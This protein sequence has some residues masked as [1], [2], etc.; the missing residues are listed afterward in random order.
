MDNYDVFSCLFCECTDIS[1]IVVDVVRER[2]FSL[3]TIDNALDS[4]INWRSEVIPAH[5]LCVIL[6][7]K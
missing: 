5:C 3:I 2:N 6:K 7:F 4:L 1:C